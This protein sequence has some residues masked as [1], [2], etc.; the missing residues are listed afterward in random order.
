MSLRNKI[1]AKDEQEE[2]GLAEEEEKEEREGEE[3]DIGSGYL[4]N[5][6]SLCHR[7]FRNPYG[8]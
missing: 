1:H 7:N 4:V 3:E 5:F 2:K 8:L 6:T